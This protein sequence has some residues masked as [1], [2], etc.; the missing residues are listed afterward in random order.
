VDTDQQLLAR[1]LID[2]GLTRA[3][4]LQDG[5]IIGIA[6]MLMPEQW[7]LYYDITLDFPGQAYCYHGK[8]AAI[9]ALETFDPATMKEPSGW[10]K[11]VQTNRCRP[12][13][14]PSKE[15]IGWPV[16]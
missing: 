16:P 7:R 1:F 5:T 6:K 8:A 15:T 11:H 2:I 14:D 4:I 10:V 3:R 13:G 12:G 9:E